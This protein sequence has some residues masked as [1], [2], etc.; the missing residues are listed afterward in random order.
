MSLGAELFWVQFKSVKLSATT[1]FWNLNRYKT[2]LELSSL[3]FLLAASL[4]T[5]ITCTIV[6]VQGESVDK[7]LAQGNVPPLLLKN[8]CF[9]G[10]QTA[11][12]FLKM[13]KLR[14]SWRVMPPSWLHIGFNGGSK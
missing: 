11:F 3:K 10:P 9:R 4:Q 14:Q 5:I 2:S 1:T 13:Y 7:K 12:A 8:A 6:H